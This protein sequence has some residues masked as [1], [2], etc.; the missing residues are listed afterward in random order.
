[1]EWNNLSYVI[2]ILVLNFLHRTDNN[3]WNIHGLEYLKLTLNW[4]I[5]TENLI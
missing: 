1:M 5:Y 2:E 4:F 3:L